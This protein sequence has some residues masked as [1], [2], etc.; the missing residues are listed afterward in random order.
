MGSGHLTTRHQTPRSSRF[1]NLHK[2][3]TLLERALNGLD[4]PGD[5]RLLYLL[6]QFASADL[7]AACMYAT[8][9]GEILLGPE[10]ESRWFR[11]EISNHWNRHSMGCHVTAVCS[12]RQHAPASVRWIR[13]ECMCIG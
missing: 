9:Q 6:E 13:D 12:A 3:V 4:F 2:D 8:I 11:D 10:N 1:A 5:F 7:G